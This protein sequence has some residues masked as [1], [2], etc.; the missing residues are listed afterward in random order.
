M[1]KYLKY[2]NKNN[3][4]KAT[5]QTYSNVLKQYEIFWGDI[6]KIKKKLFTYLKS[7]NTIWTHYNILCAF[8]RFKNDKRLNNLKEIK[9][10]AIPKIYMPVFSKEFLMEK[11]KDQSKYKNVVIR[12][13]FETGIR[14]S[15]LQSI[16]RIKG[17]TILLKGKGAKI[18]EIFHNPNTTKFFKGF[19]FTSKTLRLWV[20]DVLGREYTPHSI[21]RSHATHML[22]KGANPKMV[23][24]QLGH[25][26]I[27]TTYRYLHMSK[28][29][30]RKIY[31]K[32]F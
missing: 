16:I 27:E 30:N 3:Y 18:R 31:N 14:A 28:S 7:P 15:E 32:Y 17:D 26:K 29:Q 4:S 5:I 20:K 9:L 23:M 10:P 24:L 2:L 8:M 11:T 22:L 13:L 6:R 19:N 21:R 1:E 25:S 12:F